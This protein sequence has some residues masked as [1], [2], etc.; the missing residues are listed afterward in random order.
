MLPYLFL[1]AFFAVGAL[2]SRPQ[3]QAAPQGHGEIE[4]PNIAARPSQIPIMLILGGILMALMI[5]T[6][7]RVGGDWETY[8]FYWDYAGGSTLGEMLD[9]GDPAYQFLNWLGQQLGLDI[10]SVNLVCGSLFTWGLIRFA[11]TQPMPWLVVVVAIPYLVM[12]VAMGY[13]RQAVAI[14]LLL[15][16]LGSLFRGGSLVR[17]AMYVI[18]A[19]LFHKTA[20]LALPLIIFSRERNRLLTVVGGLLLFYALYVS[21]LADNV[22]QL[23]TNYIE[24]QYQSSGAAIRVGL[25]L[26][27]ALLFLSSPARFAFDDLQRGFFRLSSWVT[28]GLLVALLTT[29]S[30]TAVDRMALYMFPL[31]LAVMSRLPIAYPRLG[32]RFAIICYALAVQLVWLNF[33]DF[34]YK[35]LPYRTYLL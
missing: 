29:P 26:I 21:L 22:D 3:D 20:V 6:R 18:L 12:V 27:P 32:S 19:A 7:F 35:W 31:Q 13:T 8:T 9:F 11:R 2:F 5:G 16:G 1:F 4:A 15:G 28:I 33:A 23:V 34:A 10:W 17:F 30:S 14:G 25:S 24:A